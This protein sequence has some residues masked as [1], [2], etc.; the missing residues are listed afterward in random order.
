MPFFP[1]GELYL[2]VIALYKTTTYLSTQAVIKDFLNSLAL[3]QVSRTERATLLFLVGQGFLMNF[4]NLL[5]L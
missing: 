2:S 3:L 5:L 1:P 4:I